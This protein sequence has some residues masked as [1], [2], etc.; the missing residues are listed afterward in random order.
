MEKKKTLKE[1]YVEVREILV[2]EDRADLVEFID[3]RIAQ[4]EK[5]AT[6]KKP[7]KAQEENKALAADVLAIMGTEKMT[8]TEVMNKAG[9]GSNQKATAI[10]KILVTEG[11]VQ[12]TEDGKKVYFSLV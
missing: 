5:K 12:R 2:A 3:S 1:Q 11:K 7:T 9:L 8:A 4:V 6:D 10:L